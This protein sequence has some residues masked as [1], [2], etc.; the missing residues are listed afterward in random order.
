M[1]SDAQLIL[2]PATTGKSD[3]R[4]A[5]TSGGLGQGDVTSLTGSSVARGT[6]ASLIAEVL[7]SPE[8]AAMVAELEDARETGR[9]GYGSRALVGGCLVKSL[10]AIPTWSRTARLIAEHDALQDALGGVPSVYALYRFSAKLRRFQ[11]V[12]D[13]CLDRLTASLSVEMPDYGR[14]IAIDASDL[15]AFANGQRFVSKGGRER[16]R[17]SDSDASWGHRS[18]VS[19]RKGGGFYGYRL[20]AA[21][22]SRTGLPIAWKTATARQHESSLADDL[23]QRVRERVRPET[24]ALDKGYDVTPVYDA[25][26][27]VGVLPIIPLRETPFVRQGKHGAP[28]CEHGTWTFWGAD[29]KRN[30]A[31]WRCPTGECS[32]SSRWVKADRLHP[33]VPRDSKRWRELY[34]GRAAVEREFGRLKHD[35]GLAPLRVRGLQRVALHADLVMLARLSLALARARAVPLAA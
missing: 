9:K 31:K 16:E 21:V 33:L 7:D 3:P 6:A 20:H 28:T 10:Y 22:C 13:A 5:P 24:A 15:P 11:P 35:Y 1:P 2:S 32:P 26:A 25:C 8:I 34:R 23:L 30:A 29:T 19:T 18:A 17:F 14:D 12:L 27:R 4:E